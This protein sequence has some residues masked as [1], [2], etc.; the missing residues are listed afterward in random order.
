ML[1]WIFADNV[2]GIVGEAGALQPDNCSTEL[3]KQT[4]AFIGRQLLPH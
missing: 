2:S 3:A 1:A 4:G